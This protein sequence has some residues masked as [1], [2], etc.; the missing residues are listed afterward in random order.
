MASSLDVEKEYKDRTSLK[1]WLQPTFASLHT[2]GAVYSDQ[3]GKFCALFWA[4]TVP[5]HTNNG[6]PLESRLTALELE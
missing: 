3:K 4:S 6:I 1:L 5:T 2:G